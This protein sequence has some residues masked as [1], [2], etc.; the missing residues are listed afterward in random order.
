[1]TAPASRPAPMPAALEA[2]LAP[3]VPVLVAP[4]AGGPSTPELVAAVLRAGG[5]GF[6][7]GGMRT[8]DEVREQVDRLRTLLGDDGGPDRWGVN[9][10]VPDAVNTAVPAAA[11]TPE[12]L[13]ARAEAVAAHRGRLAPLAA[14]LDAPL[15]TAADV[16]PDPMRERE[17]FAAFLA[18]AEEQAWPAV[19]FTFGL[20]EPA[21]FDRFAAAGIPAGVTVTSAAEAR[22]AVGNGAAFLVVQGPEA[23][24]HR[25][26][27]DPAARPGETDL[28][29]LLAEVR[30]A[31]GKVPVPLVA[32]GGVTDAG[33]VGALL[34]AGATA[35]S[36]GT[37][38][39]LTPEAGTSEA[40]R[41]ALR[42]AAA[43]AAF[44]RPDDGGAATAV[45]RAFTGR[46]A[47][48][49]VTPFM[50]EFADAP[51]AYP[52]VNGLTGPLRKAAAARGDLE[53]VHLWAGTGAH[54]VVEQDAASVLAALDPRA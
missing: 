10:F 40:H 45:T 37:A 21:V 25:G 41:T 33:R 36:T 43:G 16:T 29:T 34:A 35:V 23:G 24:G 54:R 31:L 13:A 1:M 4:M 18:A 32:A 47:R 20:P 11:R 27:L 17:Q 52:E 46:W 28:P 7:A 48:S 22:A 9:L 2:V 39:L 44:T 8:P 3:S 49:I 15:P 30:E 5:G 6:L 38:F 42:Q 12:A 19:S 14:D 50:A 53:H 26:T 51:A